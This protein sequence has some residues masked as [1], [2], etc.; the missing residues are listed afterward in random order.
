MSV[1]SSSQCIEIVTCHMIS[2]NLSIRIYLR[3]HNYQLTL[4]IRKNTSKKQSNSSFCFCSVED[5]YY[6]F[7]EA[8]KYITITN[9]VTNISS[10]RSKSIITL[11]ILLSISA[12]ALQQYGRI[13]WFWIL[14]FVCLR[15]VQ[16]HWH[17]RLNL[18]IF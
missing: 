6:L 2:R 9:I 13:C 10:A 18:N 16:T 17:I 1:I 8:L 15:N 3:D 5:Q 12:N 11:W 14:Y 4:F 7:A